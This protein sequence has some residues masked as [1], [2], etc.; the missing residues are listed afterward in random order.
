MIVGEGE[1]RIILAKVQKTFCIFAFCDKV[2]RQRLLPGALELPFLET[3][4]TSF[5]ICG[6]P[7][8][9]IAVVDIVISVI[10]SFKITF[11]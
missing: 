1:F 10:Y 5:R 8:N 6:L 11:Q 3:I 2:I 7:I 4:K 9:S